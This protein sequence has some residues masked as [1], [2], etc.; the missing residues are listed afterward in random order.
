M[1]DDTELQDAAARLIAELPEWAGELRLPHFEALLEFEKRMLRATERCAAEEEEMDALLTERGIG[2]RDPIIDHL[3]DSERAAWE[4]S[5]RRELDLERATAA[6]RD[7]QRRADMS[8][9][10]GVEPPPRSEMTITED[11]DGSTVLI[12]PDLPGS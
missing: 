10:T 8:R 9:L 4:A 5:L 6:F 7:W 1:T 3:S 2:D 12:V 11:P